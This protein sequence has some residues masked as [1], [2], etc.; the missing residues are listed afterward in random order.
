MNK[1]NLKNQMI[2]TDYKI[3]PFQYLMKNKIYRKD[4]AQ[5]NKMMNTKI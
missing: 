3:D 4:N 5:N 1:Y 2:S